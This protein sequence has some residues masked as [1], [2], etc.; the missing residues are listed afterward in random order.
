M[1][2]EAPSFLRARSL[3][4]RIAKYDANILIS[5][6]TGTGKDLAARALHYLGKFSDG[7]F[8][9]VNCGGIP[10]EL[11]ENEL[12]GHVTGAYT[13]AKGKQLGYIEQADG[14]TLFLDEI[15]TLSL[16][17]QTTL[18]RFLQDQCYKP[19]GS[20][21]IR[22]TS[23]RIIAATNSN[24]RVLVE[25]RQFRQD[26]LFRLDVLPI[27]LPSLRDRPGDAVLLAEHFIKKF[28]REFEKPIL[29]LH[30]DF[31]G[32]METYSWP[33]NIRE[34]ENTLLRAF[35]L[36]EGMHVVRIDVQNSNLDEPNALGKFN[37]QKA[38]A[39]DGFERRY[40]DRLLIE[41]HGN[42]SRAAKLAGKERR[43]LGKLLQKHGINRLDYVSG[44][45]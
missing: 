26:L 14:G 33:G 18:L 4:Q 16:K 19:L 25:A 6:E 2:G 12:F 32:W 41:S 10:D 43:A 29:P 9:A 35:L 21:K 8:I 38:R 1:I 37:E 15:D 40:L 20:Q 17:A 13:D 44:D 34:L 30:P 36:S 45:H 42:V 3:I 7:P 24:L 23:I 28:S 22:H 31:L 11:F 27:E 39:I 5:G